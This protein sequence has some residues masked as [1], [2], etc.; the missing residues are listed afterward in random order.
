MVDNLR[1]DI[2]DIVRAFVRSP[3]SMLAATLMLVLG[4][5]LN[6]VM[7]S[8]VHAALIRPLPFSDSER[9]VTVWEVHPKRGQTVLS[10]GSFLDLR[11][12]NS[13]FE[14]ITGSMPGELELASADE[15]RLAM[16]QFVLPNFFSVFDVDA[17]HG[18]ALSSVDYE[19]SWNPEHGLYGIGDAIVLS[20]GFWMRA[21]GGD[22]SV[23]GSYVDLGGKRVRIVGV[24]SRGLSTVFPERELFV[25][26][27]LP[28][29]AA[30]ARKGHEIITFARLKQ[31]IRLETAAS[32][33]ASL[34]RRFEQDHPESNLGWSSKVLPL[35]EVMFGPSRPGLLALLGGASLV[36]LA[37][38]FNAANLLLARS[39]ARRRELAVRRALG[40]SPGRIFRQLLTEGVVIALVAGAVAVPL[41]YGV[42]QSLSHLVGTMTAFPIEARID[43]TFLLFTLGV[44]IMSGV[45]LGILPAMGAARASWCL[46]RRDATSNLERGRTRA[47]LLASQVALAMVLLTVGGLFLQ[48]LLHLESIDPEFNSD[49]LLTVN[50]TLPSER[51]AEPEAQRRF[52]ARLLEEVRSIPGVASASTSM[53]LPFTRNHLNLTFGIE[54]R[55][56]ARD[57]F[58]ASSIVISDGYFHTLGAR[59]LQGRDIVPEDRHDA[60]WVA[61]INETMARAYWPGENP[62][63]KRIRFLYDWIEDRWVS[64]VGVVADIPYGAPG[65]PPEPVL[66]VPHD[67]LGSVMSSYLVVRAISTPFDVLDRIRVRIRTIDPLLPTAGIRAIDD[68]ARAFF[69]APR[70]RLLLNGIYAILTFALAAGGL[71]A[72]MAQSVARRRTELGLRRALGATEGQVLLMVLAGGMRVTL[73]GIFVGGAVTIAVSRWI[74]S[75]LFGVQPYDGATVAGIALLLA[76]VACFACYLPARRAADIDPAEALRSE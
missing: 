2:R 53:T 64:V 10:P 41:C 38:C 67:Q 29:D 45:G 35:R 25:P 37:A 5:G 70:T 32:A 43:W 62:I 58:S 73:A 74:T 27:I 33:V 1:F 17:I 9:L 51:Y 18:R 21:F 49:R 52:R 28:S 39:T 60:P 34:Y 7:F 3:T 55:P 48:T 50:I 24:M 19:V 30:Q 56:S 36:L 26:W 4:G 12:D 47:F 20:Q 23:V 65:M 31:G 14:N 72:M 69:G 44:A 22:A 6:T 42:V 13:V 66:Y 54:G 68:V 59:L 40:A 57:D 16:V 11:E 8:L 61:V 46:H 63:G 71:Y 15:P 76:G 75:L